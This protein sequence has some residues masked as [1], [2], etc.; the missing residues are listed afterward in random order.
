MTMRSG[1]EGKKNVCTR[2]DRAGLNAPA[3]DSGQIVPQPAHLETQV[4]YSP[5][6][7]WEKKTFFSR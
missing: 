1:K 2:Q 5:T 6:G 4:S 3:D 7:A